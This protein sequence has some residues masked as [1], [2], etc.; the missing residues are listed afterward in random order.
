ML[1]FPLRLQNLTDAYTPHSDTL[2]QAGNA[3]RCA[4]PRFRYSER[5]SLSRR[6]AAACLWAYLQSVACVTQVTPSPEPLV[7][8][9][10]ILLT[11]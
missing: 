11:L 4:A 1:P 9:D 3:S 7:H 6:A 5:C 8:L 2:M 10:F